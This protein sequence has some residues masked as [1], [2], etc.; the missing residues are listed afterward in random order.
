MAAAAVVPLLAYGAVSILSLRSGAQTTVVEGNQDIAN[1]VGDQIEQYLK[2]SVGILNAI[3]AEMQGTGLVRWQQDRILKNFA[4][5]FEEFTELTLLDESGVP[6]ASSRIGQPT[7]QIPGSGS[8]NFEGVLVSPFSVDDDLLPNAVVAVRQSG[9]GWLLG[10][11]RLESLW[12]TVDSIRVGKEGYALV[13]T[14]D[15]QAIAHG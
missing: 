7:T 10:R 3:A 2:N 14:N 5:Q 11:L 8:V 13:V 1:R 9:G 4:L 6:V 15:G 12:S